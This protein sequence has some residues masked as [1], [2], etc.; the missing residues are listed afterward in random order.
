M[1][2]FNTAIRKKDVFMAL[3]YYRGPA[4]GGIF[5]FQRLYPVDIVFRFLCHNGAQCKER[6]KVRERHESVNDVGKRPHKRNLKIRAA[7]N[8]EYV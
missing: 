3:P 4:L 1:S 7:E 6:D 5:L 8:G 2:F